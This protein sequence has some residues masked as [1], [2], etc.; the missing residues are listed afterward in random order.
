MIPGAYELT[1][2]LCSASSRA[3][4]GAFSHIAPHATLPSGTHPRSASTHGPQTSK[5]STMEH[6]R[7]L[8]ASCISTRTRSV[9]HDGICSAH[10]SSLPSTLR[11]SR[12]KVYMSSNIRG[13]RERQGKY[14]VLTMRPPRPCLIIWRAACLYASIT[15]RV[16]TVIMRSQSSTVMSTMGR[17]WIVPALATI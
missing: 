15:L 8:E 3:G 4:G 14:N 17:R 11:L 6:M 1:V 7:S 9:K 10:P 16:F 5:H 12:R 2:M 13:R